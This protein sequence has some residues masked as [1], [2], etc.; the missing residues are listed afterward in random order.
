MTEPRF[1]GIFSCGLPMKDY[2]FKFEAWK[3]STGNRNICLSEKTWQLKLKRKPDEAKAMERGECGTLTF[4]EHVK[5]EAS[6]RWRRDVR[7]RRETKNHRTIVAYRNLQS[8]S[9][10]Q[11]SPDL[12]AQ[13]QPS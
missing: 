5:E 4:K 3:R 9:S 2:K 8:L 13:H 10:E 12:E 11:V 6:D 1:S 7:E